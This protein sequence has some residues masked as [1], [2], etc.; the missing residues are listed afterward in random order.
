MYKRQAI[1]AGLRDQGAVL[2]GGDAQLEFTYRYATPEER[3]YLDSI[4]T[5]VSEI[6]DFRPMVVAGDTRV[7]TQVKAVDGNYPPVSYTHLDVYKRQVSS[8]RQ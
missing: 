2:L 3:A 4:A 1:E 8:R 6:V 7:L 5:R